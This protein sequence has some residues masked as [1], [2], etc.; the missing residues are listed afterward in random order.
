MA[1]KS[2]TVAVRPTVGAE[3]RK[4]TKMVSLKDGG[5]SLLTPYHQAKS[6]F[7]AKLPMPKDMGPHFRLWSEGVTYTAENRVKLSYHAD[8]FAQFSSESGGTITSGI[9]GA[10]GKPKG[11]GVRSNPLSTPTWS[12]AVA[13]I[14]VWGIDD[15]LTTKE[16]ACDTIIYEPDECYYRGCSPNEADGWIL[17]IHTFPKNPPLP[18]RFRNNFPFLQVAAQGRLLSP[19][20]YIAEYR[21]LDLQGPVILGL[22]LNRIATKFDDKSRAKSGWFLS[23]PSDA[24]ATETTRYQLMATYPRSIGQIPSEGALDRD[25]ATVAEEG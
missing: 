20:Q 12:G 24:G 11:L 25:E 15:Y 19:L 4:I 18:I 9:D 1:L 23:G 8:G 3:P 16:T 21:V 10:T 5:F 7:L 22:N 17:T 6:G 2:W 14:T 13:A